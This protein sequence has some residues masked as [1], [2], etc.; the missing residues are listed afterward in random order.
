MCPNL[1]DKYQTSLAN[2]PQKCYV[3]AKIIGPPWD[4]GTDGGGGGEGC[5]EVLDGRTGL[6]WGNG[7]ESLFSPRA[8][9]LLGVRGEAYANELS[10]VLAYFDSLRPT[11]S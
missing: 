11:G 3:Y 9:A 7:R 4:R 8:L 2:A 1:A 6:R 5:L 10:D